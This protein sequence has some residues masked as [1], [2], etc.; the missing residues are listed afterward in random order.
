MRCPVLAVIAEKDDITPLESATPIVDILRN[1]EVQT[2]Q[3]DAGHVSLFAGRQAVKKVMP[4]VFRWLED[5]SD[6]AQPDS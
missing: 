1:A 2:L 3:V 4:E 6:E 5:H